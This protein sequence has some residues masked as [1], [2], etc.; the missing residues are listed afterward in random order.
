MSINLFQIN[1][2]FG[3][4]VQKDMTI[5]F[6]YPNDADEHHLSLAEALVSYYMYM[7]CSVGSFRHWIDEQTIL[8]CIQFLKQ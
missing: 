2:G 5:Q 6:I 1:P 7:Y 8:H 3:I 4:R